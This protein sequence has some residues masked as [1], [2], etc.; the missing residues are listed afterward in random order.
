M[1]NKSPPVTHLVSRGAG[2]SSRLENKVP[3]AP[4]DQRRDPDS[5]GEGRGLELRGIFRRRR[6][7]GRARGAEAVRLHFQA[8]L[9]D[10]GGAG[11]GVRHGGG[12][13]GHGHKGRAQGRRQSDRV[14]QK[15]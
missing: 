9:R 1:E 10:A 15:D 2:A 14:D 7:R 12:L 5:E 13:P 6:G 11:V 4:S 3:A 8:V